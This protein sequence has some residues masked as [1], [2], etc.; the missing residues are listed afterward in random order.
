VARTGIIDAV[1]LR[2]LLV[3][4]VTVASTSAR[5]DIVSAGEERPASDNPG[6]SYLWDGGAIPFFWGAIAARMTI[7]R[8]ASP[9]E[10][11]LLFSTSEGGATQASWEIPGWGVTALGGVAIAGMVGSGDRSR[12]YHAKGL[13][14]SL[15]TGVVVT[16]GLK[17]LFGRRRPSYVEGDSDGE[18]RSFPSGHS[19][20]AFAIAS[21]SLLFLN[22]HVFDRDRTS[23][24]EVVTYAGVGMLAVGLAGERVIHNRHHLTDVMCGGLLGIT[25]STLFYAYQER[26]YRRRS[27]RSTELSL[28]PHATTD[29]LGL[30]LDFR[31]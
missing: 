30:R 21:Y 11:P 23:A 6:I 24:I 22:G 2:S 10:D 16:G 25:S 20:Q 27:V 19:T 13:A 3:V 29:S 18:R 17:V 14:E 15:A 9:R 26:R 5:A 31:W 4:A 1:F 7:D 12:W 8:M 28:A